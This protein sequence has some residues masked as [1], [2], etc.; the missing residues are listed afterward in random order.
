[1][2]YGLTLLHDEVYCLLGYEMN[3]FPFL[4][5]VFHCIF[6]TITLSIT[7]KT[8]VLP[9]NLLSIFNSNGTFIRQINSSI[10]S[11][12]MSECVWVN[13]C[14]FLLVVNICTVKISCP[15]RLCRFELHS[16]RNGEQTIAAR[17]NTN[18]RTFHA[19]RV[20]KCLR[21]ECATQWKYYSSWPQIETSIKI[22]D[23]MS[24]M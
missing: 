15:K 23:S 5:L 18:I 2:R 20:I 6:R 21:N 22:F 10:A 16:M 14:L 13:A 12:F 19:L 9:S 24:F 1:M 3:E 7:F 8:P 11:R 4:L 17:W